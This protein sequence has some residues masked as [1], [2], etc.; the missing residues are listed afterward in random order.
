MFYF[1]FIQIWEKFIYYENHH[2]NRC[3]R[4]SQ[5]ERRRWIAKRPHAKKKEIT[6]CCGEMK[7]LI[8]IKCFIP[9]TFALIIIICELSLHI[10]HRDKFRLPFV[11]AHNCMDVILTL[12][13]DIHTYG[14]IHCDNQSSHSL[15]GI[16]TSSVKKSS[17]CI[18]G[19]NAIKL[20]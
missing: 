3:N 7:K 5:C 13:I 16:A 11:K 10:I 9:S 2:H 18:H 17:I 4:M 19:K 20:S 12:S 15:S 14:I 8:T 1:D 6:F